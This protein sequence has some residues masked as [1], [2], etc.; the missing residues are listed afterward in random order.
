VATFSLTKFFYLGRNLAGKH[1]ATPKFTVKDFQN[2]VKGL[3]EQLAQDFVEH[4]NKIFKQKDFDFLAIEEE[5]KLPI[6][7]DKSVLYEC[8]DIKGSVVFVKD[9]VIVS[10]FTYKELIHIL[11]YGKKDKGVMPDPVMRLAFESFKPIYKQRVRKF[12]TG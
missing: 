12:I 5:E 9:G 11:D 3:S 8:L 2:G 6:H 7:L 10:D 4:C 1:K